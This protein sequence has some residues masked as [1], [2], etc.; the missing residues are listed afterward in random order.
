VQ[1][2]HCRNSEERRRHAYQEVTP[3]L[4]T[5]VL[6]VEVFYEVGYRGCLV[7]PASW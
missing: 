3:P 4:F 5:N 7:S 2:V 6:E 1:V